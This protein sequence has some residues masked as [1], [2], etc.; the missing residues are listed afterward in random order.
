MGCGVFLVCVTQNPRNML[1]TLSDSPVPS[2]GTPHVSLQAAP[3]MTLTAH[4]SFPGT[5]QDAERYK[6]GQTGHLLLRLYFYSLSH[7]K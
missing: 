7:K 2:P 4:A 1:L 6:A 5:D 3:R